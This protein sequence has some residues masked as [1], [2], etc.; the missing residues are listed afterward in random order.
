Y[1]YDKDFSCHA[2][3]GYLHFNLST[4]LEKDDE[5]QRY[6]EFMQEFTDMVV[7]KYNVSLKAEH[8]T[9]RNMEQFVAKE[10]VMRFKKK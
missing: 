2:L 9:G 10:W 7:K 3:T 8:G 5:V 6:K 1:S 4:N